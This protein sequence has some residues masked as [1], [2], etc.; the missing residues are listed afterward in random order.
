MARAHEV[1]DGICWSSL[2]VFLK[3]RD[4][5]SSAE[6]SPSPRYHNG[7]NGRVELD[8]IQHIHDAGD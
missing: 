4:V 3:R 2:H 7:A 6:R 5:G 8:A 1:R